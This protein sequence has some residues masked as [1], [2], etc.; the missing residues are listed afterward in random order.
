MKS[1]TNIVISICF[2]HLFVSSL[3]ANEPPKRFNFASMY[4]PSQYLLHPQILLFS[5]SDTSA[6]LFYKF[7]KRNLH[8]IKLYNHDTTVNIK[9]GYE[10]RNVKTHKLVNSNQLNL[11]ISLNNNY[12]TIENHFR[13][14]FNQNEH[15]KVFINFRG[16]KRGAYSINIFDVDNINL[17]N[18]DLRLLNSS[19]STIVYDKFVDLQKTYLL[20]SSDKT[21][22][23]LIVNYYEF[24]E[25]KLYPPSQ[26]I[27]QKQDLEKPDSAFIYLLG[28]TIKFANE[29]LYIFRTRLADHGYSLLCFDKNY[30]K[31]DI[32]SS[33]KEPIKLI[34]NNKEYREIESSESLKLD[35]D[36]FWLDRSFKPNQAKE[37]IRVFYNRIELANKLF[38]DNK[39]GWKTDRGMIFIMFGSPSIV[40][41]SAFS[42]EWYYGESVETAPIA[43]IF[44]KVTDDFGMQTYK[45]RR[46]EIYH[47]VWLSAIS[48]WREGRVYT[49]NRK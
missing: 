38:L 25:Y 47:S 35:I 16:E 27:I 1:L 20:T 7:S 28:D 6:I 39:E 48:S 41:I 45:M 24:D 34:A 43:F 9:I 2:L 19:D 3:Y 15:H 36:K 49:I 17:Q 11:A 32:I 30:P 31:I 13:L 8:N 40:N 10:I 22:T 44:D 37:Q 12:E 46:D 26:E 18:N 33:M 29:G 23:E 21:K 5:D 42:E 4:N 14:S